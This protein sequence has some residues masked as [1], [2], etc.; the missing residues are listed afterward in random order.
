MLYD[1]RVLPPPSAAWPTRSAT[2]SIPL[3]L[4][5]DGPALITSLAVAMRAVAGVEVVPVAPAGDPW[6]TA[7]D[8]DGIQAAVTE[9][10]ARRRGVPGA[11]VGTAAGIDGAAA[12]TMRAGG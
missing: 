11:S 5:P 4:L 8:R 1:R 2:S 3:T 12:R 7:G 9:R 6:P 10:A